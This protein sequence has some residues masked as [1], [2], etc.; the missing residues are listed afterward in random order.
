MEFTREEL[1]LLFEALNKIDPTNIFTV[2]V[3][4]KQKFLTELGK[5]IVVEPPTKRKS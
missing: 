5:A 3:N 2:T 1:Q 4:L